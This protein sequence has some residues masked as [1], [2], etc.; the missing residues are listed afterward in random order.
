M[1]VVLSKT[2]IEAVVEGLK[3][4]DGYMKGCGVS[5]DDRIPYLNAKSK[6]EYLYKRELRKTDKLKRRKEQ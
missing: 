1:K 5:Y 3:R 2:D 4:L 6:I